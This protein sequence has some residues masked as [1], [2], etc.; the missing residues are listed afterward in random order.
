MPT[1]TGEGQLLHSGYIF[2]SQS[3]PENRWFW[4][5]SKFLSDFILGKT[6]ISVPLLPTPNPLLRGDHFLSSKYYVKNILIFLDIF[7]YILL[8][9]S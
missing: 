6:A 8:N 4:A 5:Y 2:K 3:H 9:Y 1:G 7:V